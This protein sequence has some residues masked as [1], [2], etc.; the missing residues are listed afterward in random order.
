[1]AVAIGGSAGSF[2]T[3]L[4]LLPHLPKDYGLAVIVVLHQHRDGGGELAEALAAHCEIPVL[5]AC[6]KDPIEP[7]IVYVCPA[8]Y[9]ILVEGE[10]TFALSTDPPVHFAR[11]SIDVFF[12]SAARVYRDRLVGVLLSGTGSDGAL[13]LVSIKLRGGVV[14]CEDPE[15]AS[16][17]AMPR[18]GCEATNV[19]WVGSAEVIGMRLAGLDA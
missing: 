16:Q 15:M 17:S 19:D 18:A 8:N 3:L 9:H 7:G 14:A 11:P 2:E 4:R 1:M 5:P 6:D 13:G 12:E 10:R